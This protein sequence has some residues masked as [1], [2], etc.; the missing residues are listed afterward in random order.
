MKREISVLTVVGECGAT[1]YDSD[2]DPSSI[3]S[4]G[5]GTTSG[6]LVQHPLTVRLMHFSGL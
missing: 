1:R 4:G 2:R 6:P 3:S 5:A